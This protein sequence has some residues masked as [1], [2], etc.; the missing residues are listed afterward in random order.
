MSRALL[1]FAGFTSL[2]GLLAPEVAGGLTAGYRRAEQYIS[3]LGA[4]GAPHADLVNY[5][6]FLATAALSLICVVWLSTRLPSPLRVPSLLLLGLAMGNLGAAVFP[7]DAGCPAVGSPQQGL[8]NLIGLVQ[9]VSGATAMI[10]MG[11][12]ARSPWGPL[13]IAFGI[14]VLGCLYLMGGP[15]LAYRGL[16]QRL[17]ELCLYL[18][19]PLSAW[20]LTQSTPEARA[21]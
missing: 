18:W 14:I 17:A 16:W 10:W 9:Y 21:A 11:G 7:C 15:G 3:E 19:L 8:H 13:G 4:S 12:R 6:I 2:F 20:K 5:G 1:Y